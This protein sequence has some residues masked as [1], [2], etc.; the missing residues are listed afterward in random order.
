MNWHIWKV[1]IRERETIFYYCVP[2]IVLKVLLLQHNKYK[3]VQSYRLRQIFFHSS[4]KHHYIFI[5][6]RQMTE[7]ERKGEI[8]QPTTPQPVWC[9]SARYLIA[10]FK[11]AFHLLLLQKTKLYKSCKWTFDLTI[12]NLIGILEV[13]QTNSC[14]HHWA[15]LTGLLSWADSGMHYKW[16]QI[17]R[18]MFN[19]SYFN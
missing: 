15:V 12:H 4:I 5:T 6:R 9:L 3:R 13:P 14:I 11:P 16:K 18:E 1:W 19:L 7:T 2:N 10:L 8:N 17:I